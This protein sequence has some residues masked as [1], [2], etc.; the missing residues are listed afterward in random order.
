ME[1]FDHW[2]HTAKTGSDT[3]YT[4]VALALCVGLLFSWAQLA[5][6][7]C[8]AIFAATSARVSGW[9]ERAAPLMNFRCEIPASESPPLFALRI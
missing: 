1:L 5:A 8:R 2:D 3:E 4:L 6:A 9:F 7:L